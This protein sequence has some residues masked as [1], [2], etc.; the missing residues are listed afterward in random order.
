[1]LQKSSLM[2]QMTICK[3]I[4]EKL[5]ENRNALKR[6]AWNTEKKFLKEIELRK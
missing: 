4:Y 2:P 6:W 5:I 3:E 1:M